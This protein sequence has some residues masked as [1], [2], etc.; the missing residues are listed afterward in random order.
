M[1][2]ARAVVALV[3]MIA[4]GLVAASP[5]PAVILSEIPRVVFVTV[6]AAFAAEGMS[7]FMLGYPS[8]RGGV[9]PPRR[10]RLMVVGSAALAVLC[11]SFE[12][13]ASFNRPWFAELGHVGVFVASGVAMARWCRSSEPSPLYLA[14]GLLVLL[15][16]FAALRS[17]GITPGTQDAAHVLMGLPQDAAVLWAAWHVAAIRGRPLTEPRTR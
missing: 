17:T 6:L 3:T 10:L 15:S 16:V 11:F 8:Q 7:R 2:R 4:A 12:V 13:R 14:T 5:S 9:Y 1:A